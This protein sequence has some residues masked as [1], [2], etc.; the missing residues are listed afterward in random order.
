MVA[1][2]ISLLL[3]GGAAVWYHQSSQDRH[4]AEVQA[5]QARSN[6]DEEQAQAVIAHDDLSHAVLPGRAL[7]AG[8]TKPMA[9]IGQL[10]TLDKSEAAQ[11]AIQLQ[12]GEAGISGID[13]YNRAVDAANADA[14]QSNNLFQQMLDQTKDLPVD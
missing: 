9:T 12:T 11:M 8:L 6:L 3:A 10:N 2:A 14:D 5:A 4:R 1:L 7:D 13:G